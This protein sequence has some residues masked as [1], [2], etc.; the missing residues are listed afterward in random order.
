MMKK[1][2]ASFGA[3][4]VFGVAVWASGF[5]MLQNVTTN[6]T[7]F[8]IYDKGKLVAILFGE[9][10]ETTFPTVLLLKTA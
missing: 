5:E 7:I 3:W 6:N 4:A 8:P 10:G 1:L 9:D 2:L